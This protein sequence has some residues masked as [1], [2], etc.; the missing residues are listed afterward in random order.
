VLQKLD[1]VPPERESPSGSSGPA[2]PPVSSVFP[3]PSPEATKEVSRRTDLILKSGRAPEWIFIC[4]VQSGGGIITFRPGAGK[5][6]VMLLFTTPH[7]AWDYIRATKTAAEVRQLKFDA[8]PEVAKGWI[9]AGV[10]SFVMNRCPRCSVMNLFSIQELTENDR[11][12]RVW[13]LLAAVRSYQGELKVREFFT[14]NQSASFPRARAALEC[15]RDRIDCSVPYLH[16]L[17]AYY[18]RMDQDEEGKAAAVERLKE[19]GPQFADWESKWDASSGASSPW[20]RA[21]AEAMVGLPKAFGIEFSA[22]S[23]APKS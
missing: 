9:A 4:V 16:E 20:V 12:L 8:L 13:A 19:F 15:I 14:Q 11:L 6:P 21:L 3:A 5:K 22:R 1:L 10:E 18:A 7:A 17:I 2:A 23:E